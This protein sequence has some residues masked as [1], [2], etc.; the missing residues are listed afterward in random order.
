M[1]FCLR[2][3]LSQCRLLNIAMLLTSFLFTSIA[4][5]DS[6][7]NEPGM[8]SAEY[9]TT[10]CAIACQTPNKRIWWMF[11]TPNQ[12]ELRDVNVRTGLP[13]KSSE[14]WRL[15]PD[16]KLNYVYLMHQDRRAIEYLFDDLR[17]LGIAADQKKWEILTQLVT[18]DELAAMKKLPAKTTPVQ[19]FVAEL[20]TGQIHDI[21]VEITW[22]PQLNLP[23]KV[24]YIYP[25]NTVTVIL[26]MVYTS[27]KSNP[28]STKMTTE[29]QLDTYQHVYYTDIGDMEQNAEAEEWITKAEGAPG[30]HR[31]PH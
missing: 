13:A 27:D 5:S 21:K 23:A 29:Q 3:G 20:Y 19:G 24:A 12:V 22:L 10:Q 18:K 8:V 17:I 1:K 7:T 4:W 9:V 14:L 25:Q 11:R 26:Q 30:L 31:H 2:F 15:N 6:E 28:S 16:G